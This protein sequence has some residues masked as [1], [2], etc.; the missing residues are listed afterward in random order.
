M[1]VLPGNPVGRRE[2]SLVHDPDRV[3]DGEEGILGGF[4]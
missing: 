2:V 3:K 1:I 4:S